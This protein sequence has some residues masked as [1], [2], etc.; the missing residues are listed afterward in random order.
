MRRVIVST[1]QAPRAIGPY[2]QAVQSGDLL[3]LSGQIALDPATGQLVGDGDVR[4]ETEQVLANA[5]A[6]LRA[7]G[8]SFGEVAKA[9]IFLVDMA[10]FAVVNEV[11]GRAFEGLAPPAR[12]TVAVAA[13]PRG[14]RV[15]IEFVARVSG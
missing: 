5:A 14:A 2:S 12:S 1:E 9:T 6:V 13:L 7:G 8:A 10:D 15:E 4:R 11:Y 3:F